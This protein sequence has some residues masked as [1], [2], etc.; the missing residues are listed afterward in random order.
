MTRKIFLICAVVLLSS[1]TASLPVAAQ[2]TTDSC[3]LITTEIFLAKNSI[4]LSNKAK[5]R[6]DIVSKIIHRYPLT[7]IL[8]KGQGNSSEGAQQIS[9]DKAAV[10]IKYLWAKGVKKKNIV[11]NYGQNG[12]PDIVSIT[13][14]A[15]D[16]PEWVPAPHPCYSLQLPRAK[17]CVGADGEMLH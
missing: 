4:R 16:G 13:C 9:W 8:V 15:E 12:N 5:A 14:I 1:I 10:V 7:K 6:L 17:R 11:F 2:E 3:T